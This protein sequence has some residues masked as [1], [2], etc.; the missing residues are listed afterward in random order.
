MERGYIKSFRKKIFS[1]LW[2]NKNA[3]RVFEFLLHSATY[4]P[5]KYFAGGTCIDLQPG[6]YVSSD[7]VLAK[8]CF[9]SY[10]Q[11]RSSVDYL[12]T[13]Q[14]IITTPTQNYTIYSIVNWDIYQNIDEIYNALLKTDDNAPITHEQRTGNEPVTQKQEVKKLRSEEEG[15][16]QE[17]VPRPRNGRFTIPTLDEVSEHVKARGGRIDPIKFHA[18]YTS[19]GWKVGKNPMKSWRAAVVTWERSANQ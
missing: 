5:L 11:I 7:R 16:K 6:Q 1:D 2:V 3:F 14:R 19:N 8:R 17:R 15:Q 13:T 4:R 18:H 10:Q 9:I 12:K